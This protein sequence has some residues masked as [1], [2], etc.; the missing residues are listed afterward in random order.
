MLNGLQ[1]NIMRLYYPYNS[2]YITRSAEY[3]SESL[4]FKIN[5][6]CEINYGGGLA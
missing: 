2:P 5:Y 4:D 6:F 1:H 3:C